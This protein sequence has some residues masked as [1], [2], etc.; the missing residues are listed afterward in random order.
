MANSFSLQTAPLSNL[1]SEIQS[2]V[3]HFI[4][5]LTM[6]VFTLAPV[7]DSSSPAST[8]LV[9]QILVL[10]CPLPIR[11]TFRPGMAR[12]VILTVPGF[13]LIRLCVMNSD[14]WAS[15]GQLGRLRVQGTPC[16]RTYRNGIRNANTKYCVRILSL[17][18][19][20]EALTRTRS[21]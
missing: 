13:P 20:A 11:Q 15:C 5:D 4:N 18:D 16:T 8:E 9:I 1:F 10:C 3:K 12:G 14:V 7:Q 19:S 2:T 21:D 17:S 6:H